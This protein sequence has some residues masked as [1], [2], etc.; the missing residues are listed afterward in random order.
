M[1]AG[2]YWKIEKLIAFRE[3]RVFLDTYPCKLVLIGIKH[4]NGK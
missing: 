4:A 1:Q 3:I 2:K